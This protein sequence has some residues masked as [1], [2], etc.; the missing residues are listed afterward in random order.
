MKAEL[1]AN[2]ET[3]KGWTARQWAKHLGYRSASTITD[4]QTWQDLALLR[5][6]TKSEKAMDRH[7]NSKP[8]KRR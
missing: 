6:K 1:A 5:Q 3:V 4:T 8:I 7:R 2:L